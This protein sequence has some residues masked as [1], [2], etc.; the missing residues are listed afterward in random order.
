[1]KKLVA[2]G[3]L[4]AILFNIVGYRIFFLYLEREAN[5]RIESKIETLSHLDR[6]LIT[7]KI[8]INLPYQ[9]DWKGFER[10]DGEVSVN[11]KIYRYVKQRVYRDTLILLC[12]NDKEKTSLKKRAAE[13]FQQVNDLTAE[14]NKKPVFKN[15]KLDFFEEMRITFPKLYPHQA[16]YSRYHERLHSLVVLHKRKIP[17]R[18]VS[19]P[20]C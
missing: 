6:E 3:L 4:V 7:V 1:M 12:L 20:G 18:T 8:P 14:T 5:L 10:V 9:I 16:S 2:T 13:Y 11:G 15:S 19:V 17:P